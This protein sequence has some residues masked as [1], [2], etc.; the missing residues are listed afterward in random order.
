MSTSKLQNAVRRAAGDAD[1]AREFL[2]NPRQFQDEFVLAEAQLSRLEAVD[3]R[4]IKKI[5]KVLPDKFQAMVL[6]LI[7]SMAEEEEPLLSDVDFVGLARRHPGFAATI[8]RDLEFFQA[9]LGL[10]AQ[11]LKEISSIHREHEEVV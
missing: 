3:N 2:L 7:M 4:H 11:T 10:P 8:V 1:F 6:S 5:A 9:W